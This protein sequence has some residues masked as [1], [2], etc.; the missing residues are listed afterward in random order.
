MSGLE[1]SAVTPAAS[2]GAAPPPPPAPASSPSNGDGGD[3]ADL[4]AKSQAILNGDEETSGEEVKPAEAKPKVEE[5][6]EEPLDEAQLSRSY[7]R[8]RSEEKRFDRR[9]QEQSAKYLQDVE[10]HKASVAAFEK[11]KQEFESNVERARREPLMALKLLGWGYDDLVKYVADGN[12]P[13]DKIREDFRIQLDERGKKSQEE[14]AAIKKELEE[15]KAERVRESQIREAQAYESRVF[16][17]I[18]GLLK[19]D[20]AKFRYLSRADRDE[21]NR[22]V[23]QAMID[24]YQSSGEVLALSDAMLYKEK[25]LEKV[26]SWLR[27]HPEAASPGGAVKSANP[28][29]AKPETEEARPISQRETAVRGVQKVDLN[30]MTDEEREELS[31]RILSG[32]ADADLM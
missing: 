28:G 18:D 13:M 17:E 27:D 6:K 9:K 3:E 21:V 16:G 24:H 32:D 11:Q 7:A 2:N 29:A 15:T 4:L 25:R 1:G 30:A 14:L 22:E 8:L 31:R 23:L 10:S 19:Q 5:K 20:P 26:A 12:I